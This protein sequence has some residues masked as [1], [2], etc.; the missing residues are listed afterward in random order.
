VPGKKE[1]GGV[2]SRSMD[3]VCGFVVVVARSCAGGSCGVDC[4]R[5]VRK[6]FDCFDVRFPGL[7]VEIT[8]GV[9]EALANTFQLRCNTLDGAGS[10]F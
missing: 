4:R 2:D 8:P 6:T 10:S 3:D 1:A 7:V 5:L 9:A